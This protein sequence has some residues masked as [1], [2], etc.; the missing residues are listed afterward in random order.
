MG[1]DDASVIISMNPAKVKKVNEAQGTFTQATVEKPGPL[2][3]ATEEIE[4]IYKSK[5]VTK[6]DCKLYYKEL[7]DGSI[8]IRLTKLEPTKPVN[9]NEDKAVYLLQASVIKLACETMASE[10]KNDRRTRGFWKQVLTRRTP[11]ARS[12]RQHPYRSTP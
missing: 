3:C 2:K 12:E 9:L 5:F 11:A 8:C 4:S 6:Y 1:D 7:S 10:C